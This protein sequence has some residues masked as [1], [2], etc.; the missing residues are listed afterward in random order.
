ML[1][2]NAADIRLVCTCESFPE[3]YNAYYGP[4]LVG[5]LRLRAGW[6]AV[7][8][9]GFMSPAVYEV[10]DAGLGGHFP[11]EVTRRT[12][13]EQAKRAIAEWIKTEGFA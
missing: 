11:D 9:P 4:H 6:F 12:H 8:C 1:T 3:Q 7:R 13:L 5:Y 2:I 10:R